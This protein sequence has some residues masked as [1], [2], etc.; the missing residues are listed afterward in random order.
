MVHGLTV[1]T[2]RL[3][4]IALTPFGI[5]SVEYGIMEGC[6]ETD[7][8]TA[9][10][11]AADIDADVSVISRRV[12]TLVEAGLLSR[13]RTADDRR[14]VRLSLTEE[15]RSMTLRMAEQLRAR[16]SLMMRGID[17]DERSVFVSVVRRMM[18]NVEGL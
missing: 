12:N 7:G 11:L 9:T 14:R 13:L 16:E 6:L 10:E 18:A 17:E 3:A 15:G 1:A 5:S 8:I 4:E 2:S